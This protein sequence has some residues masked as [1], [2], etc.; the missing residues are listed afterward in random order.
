MTGPTPSLPPLSP[1]TK[2]DMTVKIFHG[3][4][5]ICG[6]KGVHVSTSDPRPGGSPPPLG[7]DHNAWPISNKVLS[8]AAPEPQMGD[9]K[10]AIECQKTS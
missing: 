7:P 1:A 5:T 4:V 2:Q 3:M 10:A 6:G 9:Q 8:P